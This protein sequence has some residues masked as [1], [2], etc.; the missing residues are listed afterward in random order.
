MSTLYSINSKIFNINGQI[1]MMPD[2]RVPFVIQID[3]TKGNGFNTFTL[4]LTNHT[5]DIY[6]KTSDGQRFTISNYLD[7]KRI[8]NFA[9][10]GVYTIELRGQCGW[11]FKNTG[12]CQKLT[13]I[14]SW[15]DFLFRA[16][17]YGFYGCINLTTIP[18]TGSINTTTID[19]ARLFSG[20]NNLACQIPPELL[21]RA[22]NCTNLTYLFFGCVYLNGQIPDYF[23]S[24]VPNLIFA[25]GIFNE[26]R[27]LSPYIPQR[28][29]WDVPNITTISHLFY[30]CFIANEGAAVTIPTEFCKNNPKITNMS[31]VFRYAA[32][33]GV[34]PADYFNYTPRLDNVEYMLQVAG[35]LNVTALNIPIAVIPNITKFNS[36]LEASDGR[37]TGSIQDIWTYASPTATKVNAFKNQIQLTNYSSI[38]NEWKGL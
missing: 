22:P 18:Q 28:L 30:R 37:A 13:K 6:V 8:I 32:V 16:L 34:F 20:C 38:P 19:L 27:R 7:P 1:L 17:I 36:F 21:Y 5:T 10:A 24:K 25:T 9:S 29:L 14:I 12:D 15:G 33:A 2:H 23:L 31:G 11:S 4:P 3:T 26:C 35:K